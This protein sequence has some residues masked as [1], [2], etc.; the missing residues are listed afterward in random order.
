MK[1]PEVN[2][3]WCAQGTGD[4]PHGLLIQVVRSSPGLERVS[5][6]RL[7]VATVEGT[8]AAPRLLREREVLC[9]ALLEGRKWSLVRCGHSV[10]GLVLLNAVCDAC[11]KEWGK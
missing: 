5:G 11:A 7:R 9:T 2:Q 3:Q 8:N 4:K 10:M 6:G 1:A